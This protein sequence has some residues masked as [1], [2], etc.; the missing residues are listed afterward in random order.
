MVLATIGAIV[1]AFVGSKALIILMFVVSFLFLLPLGFA[2]G[3][4]DFGTLF[5][6]EGC[7]EGFSEQFQH[8][9]AYLEGVSCTFNFVSFR[10]AID[11]EQEALNHYFTC[12][13]YLLYKYAFRFHL[14]GLIESESLSHCG[15]PW[16]L[17]KQCAEDLISTTVRLRDEGKINRQEAENY[18]GE[19]YS[20]YSLFYSFSDQLMGIQKLTDANYNCSEYSTEFKDITS[21]FCRPIAK[22]PLSLICDSVT[23]SS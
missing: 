2:T 15:N 10:G 9:T 7:H 11:C 12:E 1:G 21:K 22:A 20:F 17:L 19:S 23:V 3:S 8:S 18:V 4:A 6:S 13:P 5:V 16:N 14:F